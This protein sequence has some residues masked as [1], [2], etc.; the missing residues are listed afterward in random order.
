M[1]LGTTGLEHSPQQVGG[2][3][4]AE[5]IDRKAADHVVSAHFQAQHPVEYID[6]HTSQDGTEHAHQRAA[7]E[8]ATHNAREGPHQ[9]TSL[10]SDVSRPGALAVHAA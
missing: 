4:H 1:M 7:A 6:K 9:H 8:I 3:A 2:C 10:V 5:G